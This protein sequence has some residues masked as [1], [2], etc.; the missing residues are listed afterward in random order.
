MIDADSSSPTSPQHD[1]R[2]EDLTSVAS[3]RDCTV[4]D[5]PRPDF[6][7]WG[8]MVW[9]CDHCD[10]V[11]VSGGDGLSA[12]PT[13]TLTW[14]PGV[15]ERARASLAKYRAENPGARG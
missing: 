5:G 2:I 9:M 1:H 14:A 7:R 3:A 8:G 11:L 6:F 13:P 15:L 4:G 10:A 12:V